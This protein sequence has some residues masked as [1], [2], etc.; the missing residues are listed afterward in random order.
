MTREGF[1]YRSLSSV[2]RELLPLAEKMHNQGMSWG[3]TAESLRV[4]HTSLFIW[5]QLRKE[6]G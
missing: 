4:S 5:R 6:N 1:P 3:E 2:G